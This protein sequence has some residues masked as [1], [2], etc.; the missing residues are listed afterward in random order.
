[1][2]EGWNTRT[3]G[4][5]CRIARGG[6]PRPIQEFMTDDPDGVNWV[7]I[8]DATASGKFIYETKEKIKPSG[9]SRSRFVKPGDFLLSNSM[10]FGRPY[11]MQTTGCIH[12]GWL[13]LSDYE[14]SFDQSFLYH[15]LGSPVVFEQFDRLAAGSTVR[16]LNIELASRV[17][18]PVPPLPEQQRIVGILDQAFDGIATAKAN[19]ETNLQNARAL[20]ESHLQS[21]FTQRAEGWVAHKKTMAALCELIVDCE[22][23]T[24]PKQD[25]GIPSIR[26]PNIGKGKLLLDDV[27]RVS[28]ETYKKWTRRAEP[29]PGDLILA[30]EAPAGNVAVIPENLK[31]CLGQR[32]VLIRPRRNVFE[33]E[34]LA[35]ILLQ[36]LMQQK[37]L[38]HSRGAT[39]QHVNMKD[40]RALD[41]GAIPPLSVQRDI[42]SVVG[43]ATQETQ[44]LE[45]LYQRKLAALGDLKKTLLHQAFSGAL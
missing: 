2:K 21:V 29:L 40:I 24:A 37:L 32:T 5:A 25:K 4:A 43:K 10:S 22:H 18:L 20:F 42:I 17:S 44:R 15:L 14:K 31:V 34:F 1:M 35:L 8:S 16:N 19:F 28:E 3:L 11:I 30:R 12:D 6:S 38:A 23:K 36:P 41:V 33:P 45:S 7:K 9:V 13:V 26:T 39:V 27:Y